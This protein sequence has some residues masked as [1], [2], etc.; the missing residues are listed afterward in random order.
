M[1]KRLDELTAVE[2]KAAFVAGTKLSYEDMANPRTEYTITEIVSGR[3]GTQ[4]QNS[5]KRMAS[6][7]PLAS[8]AGLARGLRK[9]VLSIKNEA[10]RHP[11][12]VTDTTPPPPRGAK[13][14]V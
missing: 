9:L 6:R 4:E 2:R 5:C 12:E 7:M 8:T 14:H 13:N 10:G 3:W 1:N 11:E